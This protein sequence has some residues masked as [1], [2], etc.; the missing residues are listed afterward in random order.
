MRPFKSKKKTLIDSAFNFTFKRLN[1]FVYGGID[2][3]KKLIL[4]IGIL[5]LVVIHKMY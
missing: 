5:C 4:K 1:F 2:I 3:I